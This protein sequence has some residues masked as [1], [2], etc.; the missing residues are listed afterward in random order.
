MAHLFNS[1]TSQNGTA[2]ETLAT[3]NQLTAAGDKNSLIFDIKR[4]SIW[5]KGVEYGYIS[6]AALEGAGG[7]SNVINS[8]GLELPIEISSYSSDT[9]VNILRTSG[10]GS[11]GK[12]KRVITGIELNSSADGKTLTLSYSY[13]NI[14]ANQ[15]HHY[16]K[17]DEIEN[18]GHHL[19]G[20][21]ISAINYNNDGVL[22]Y[23]YSYIGHKIEHVLYSTAPADIGIHSNTIYI[24]DSPI[25]CDTDGDN[26]ELMLDDMWGDYSSNTESIVKFSI[27]SSTTAIPAISI[28]SENLAYAWE[29]NN[30]PQL[31]AG[32]IY[33]IVISFDESSDTFTL[34]YGEFGVDGGSNNS[35]VSSSG[36]H[37]YHGTTSASPGSP[38]KTVACSSYTSASDGDILYIT[39]SQGNTIESSSL[40]YNI[41][42][43]GSV[44]V[45]T[46][47]NT[48]YWYSKYDAS[49]TLKFVFSN[50]KWIF[51]DI[52][53]YTMDGISQTSGTHVITGIQ[54]YDGKVSYTY[55]A[56]PTGGSG[57][58]TDTN[59]W[60]N[61]YVNNAEFKGTGISTSYVNFV[62]GSGIQITSGGT[63]TAND[64]TI[65]SVNNK[66]VVQVP[67][68]AGGI[69]GVDINSPNTIYE[70]TGTFTTG[71]TIAI[72]I[73]GNNSCNLETQWNEEVI[74][75]STG[76]GVPTLATE[77]I[78]GG[79]NVLWEGTATQP[80]L[81]PNAV[82][83]INVSYDS[84][85]EQFTLIL[86]EFGV[87]SSGSGGGVTK[88]S[89]LGD[90]TLSSPTNGQVLTYNGSKWVNANPTGGSG[91]SSGSGSG[92]VYY[93]YT[94]TGATT[95]AKVLVCPTY[96]GADEGDLL[97]TTMNNRATSLTI[98]INSQG[99]APVY[100]S[101]G[102][103][104]IAGMNMTYAM[105][106]KFTSNKWVMTHSL[107]FG[108]SGSSSS[109][110]GSTVTWSQIQTTGTHIADININGTTTAV[111]ASSGSSSLWTTVNTG[112]TNATANNKS[113]AYI[114]GI[115]LDYNSSTNTYTLS[116]SYGIFRDTNTWRTIQYNGTNWGA[117]SNTINF[118]SGTNISL[119][120][121]G[122]DLVINS[123]ASSTGGTSGTDTWRD[124]LV[125]GLVF[126][127]IDT[128]TGAIDFI[129]GTGITL[130]T[131]TTTGQLTIGNDFGL[132]FGNTSTTKINDTTYT[133]GNQTRLNVVGTNTSGTDTVFSTL[134]L[135]GYL[136]TY[137]RARGGATYIGSY[138]IVPSLTS[139]TEI[140]TI[141]YPTA[142]GS[143][144]ATLYAPTS[145]GTTSN[146]WRNIYVNNT[147]L[148]NTSTSNGAVYFQAG[149]N[150]S[151]STSNNNTI[152]IESTGG[153]GISSVGLKFAGSASGV[154]NQN[155]SSVIT[156]SYVNL[157][158]DGAVAESLQ[159]VAG[160]GGIKFRKGNSGKQL[161]IDAPELSSYNVIKS[162]AN[163][164]NGNI[165]ISN[166]NLTYAKNGT[167]FS[168]TLSYQYSSLPVLPA[169]TIN[170][171]TVSTSTTTFGDGNSPFGFVSNFGF[172]YNKNGA[173]TS[174]TFSTYAFPGLT[175]TRENGFSY[176]YYSNEDDT[177]IKIRGVQG[178]YMPRIESPLVTH[179]LPSSSNSN[180]EQVYNIEV[181]TTPGT[182]PN[183]L[184]IV[185]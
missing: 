43:K 106:F 149:N 138:Q 64:I 158:S 8:D 146:T 31:Q 28:L 170:I 147:Q 130:N 69:T 174:Y 54:V 118:V 112:S 79:S 49:N 81:H 44:N 159:L 27:D 91:G 154:S 166:I 141:T 151:L 184:Y 83:E 10:F 23:S 25:T 88:L 47:N 51:D 33:E 162:G 131:D 108:G 171:N 38:V 61:V 46:K 96:M 76:S 122:N 78:L 148:L 55:T 168:Y 71:D 121:N 13:T 1:Y 114:A 179:A 82:Y 20:Y 156:N 48:V 3:Y 73:Y 84:N 140:A 176:M 32:G 19:A 7:L 172:A 180:S 56:M 117:D 173:I 11:S 63:N 100:Y 111:Y 127:D 175:T 185:I 6:A 37:V 41:N 133:T 58:T 143:G 145:T 34:A 21:A 65:S 135:R 99:A 50:N 86:G 110:S 181:C 2:E 153:S 178:G 30:V 75:F 182:S 14:Y 40:K 62:A 74:K 163:G 157:L 53:K 57:T 89:Q 95:P 136:G 139:G 164:V 155:T 93:A 97:F 52:I 120:R 45:Y 144:T 183:T 35:S 12:G 109:G 119:V 80:E 22:S 126:K 60:R 105:W 103:T 68:V 70:L 36:V 5:A 24:F 161:I 18:N 66:A 104:Q 177:E 87:N 42:S 132:V 67:R 125:D 160:R 72:N 113:Y 101:N 9:P 39:S 16:L 128:N 169:Y 150:V 17:T 59:T 124:I 4:K 15:S 137:M 94:T 26:I 102:T 116:Y 123:T 167:T 77:D 152:T 85:S 142:S 107:D 29:G 98:N 90:V 134:Q 92:K 115:K 129:G 165:Y